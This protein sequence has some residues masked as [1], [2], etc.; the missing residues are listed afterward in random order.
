MEL[1]IINRNYIYRHKYF[2]FVKLIAL[3]Y[4]FLLLKYTSSGPDH[5]LRA[6]EHEIQ[7]ASALFIFLTILI[8]F[9]NSLLHSKYGQ[10]IIER[11]SITIVK[12]GWEKKID[13]TEIK[14]ISVLKSSGKEFILKLDKLQIEIEINETAFEALKKLETIVPIKFDKPTIADRIKSRVQILSKN[15][16]F[17]EEPY[18]K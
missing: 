7:F 18:R 5:F 13:M 9:L 16:D 15:K 6:Y 11:E 14:S 10:V 12:N 1:T 17:M 3:I 4:I 2:V 8:S